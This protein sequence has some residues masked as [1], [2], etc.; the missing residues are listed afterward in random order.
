MTRLSIRRSFFNSRYATVC[1][2]KRNLLQYIITAAETPGSGLASPF[3][4]PMNDETQGGR[5]DSMAWPKPLPGVQ[6]RL[7]SPM[8]E[9][10]TEKD[11][12]WSSCLECLSSTPFLPR[13]RSDVWLSVVSIQDANQFPINSQ[14]NSGVRRASKDLS[15]RDQKTYA[16]LTEGLRLNRKAGP[17]R[18]MFEFRHSSYSKHSELTTPPSVDVRET[19]ETGRDPAGKQAGGLTRR[20]TLAPTFSPGLP[21]RHPAKR[22]DAYR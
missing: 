21:S 3:R 5:V 7:T 18:P 12:Q 6:T 9:R 15:L 14:S 2:R 11:S 17:T 1:I 19:V 16:W 8:V 22:G 10:R 13:V 20:D 4:R